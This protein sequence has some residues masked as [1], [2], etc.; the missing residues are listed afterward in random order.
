MPIPKNTRIRLR[1]YANTFRTSLRVCIVFYYANV[2][3]G[4][5]VANLSR[6]KTI[7]GY[8]VSS[9][10]RIVQTYNHICTDHSPIVTVLDPAEQRTTPNW[11]SV[12]VRKVTVII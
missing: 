1:R 9:I 10:I 6:E 12:T 4:I 11:I 2:Y 8:L 3:S 7:I 5:S